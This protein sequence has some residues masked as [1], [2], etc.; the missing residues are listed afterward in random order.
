MYLA[1]RS[2]PVLHTLYQL[3]QSL[4]KS[5]TQFTGHASKRILSCIKETASSGLC[6]QKDTA[7]ESVTYVVDSNWAGDLSDKKSA[8]G[9]AV[10][11]A[12]AAAYWHSRK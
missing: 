1:V 9:L 2:C 10:M 8:S 4:L 12:G 6:F 11:M 7:L 5:P 3:L